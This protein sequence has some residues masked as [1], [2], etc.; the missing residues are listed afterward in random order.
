[1]GLIDSFRQAEQ[2]A[3]RSA[4]SGAEFARKGIQAAEAS[5]L[6]RVKA[7]RKPANLE[8]PP[9]VH[10]DPE[11]PAEPSSNAKVRTG[12]VSV[13]GQDVGEMRCTGR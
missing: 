4:R 9:S 10:A 13:N 6:R 7:R 5:V 8:L 1:M 11:Q 2:Q 12:I 3:A